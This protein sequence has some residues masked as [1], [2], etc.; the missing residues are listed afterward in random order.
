MRHTIAGNFEGE[1]RWGEWAFSL[2]EL[3]VLIASLTALMLPTP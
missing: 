1:F 2:I 3:L